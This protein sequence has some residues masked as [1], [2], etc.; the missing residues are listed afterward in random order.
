MQEAAQAS[1]SARD[2]CKRPVNENKERPLAKAL[3]RSRHES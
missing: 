1:V 3:V 2:L